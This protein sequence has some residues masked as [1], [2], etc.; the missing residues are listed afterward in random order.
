MNTTMA[1]RIAAEVGRDR[2]N[3]QYSFGCD[4]ICVCGHRK[5]VHLAGGH[6]CINHET[7]DGAE[8]ECEKF[9]K[10]RKGR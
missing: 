4:A 10:S 2:T 7:G 6:E 9:R 1:A 8:C 3:G 5:G